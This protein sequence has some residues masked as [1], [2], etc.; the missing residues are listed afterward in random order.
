MPA[1]TDRRY[2]RQ[3]RR[4]SGSRQLPIST[5]L[6]DRRGPPRLRLREASEEPIGRHA[7]WTEL[8][9]DLVFVVAVAQLA[10][11]T[12]RR[13]SAAGALAFAGL[14]VPV[15]WTWTTHAY[16]ADLFD[17]DDGPF[18]AVLLG[19]MLL[20]AALAATI[21]AAFDGRTAGFVLAYAA[22]RADLLAVYAWAWRSDSALRGL[23]GPHLVD[24]SL[25]EL[26][27]LVSLALP[28][29]CATARGRWPS[30][31]TSRPASSPTCAAATC[32]ATARTCQSASGSSR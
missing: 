1:S 2:I 15:W 5:A 8:F 20:V 23:V 28:E 30:P 3:A 17:T 21:P 31:S 18:R 19:A 13:P 26:V 14:F 29:G 16:V 24:F 27:W 11:G 12:A 7:T 6:G 4:V 32:R 10:S 9:F 22:L 25:G